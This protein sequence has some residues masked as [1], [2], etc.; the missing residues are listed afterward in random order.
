MGH[1]RILQVF[2]LTWLHLLDKTCFERSSS[3]FKA[4]F[5]PWISPEQ[6]KYPYSTVFCAVAGWFL[7]LNFDIFPWQELRWFQPLDVEK[8]LLCTGF[9]HTFCDKLSGFCQHIEYL[10]MDLGVS[11]LQCSWGLGIEPDILL[12][13]LPCG[14]FTFNTVGMLSSNCLLIEHKNTQKRRWDL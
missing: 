4:N 10:F 6:L 13:Q 8:V 3:S 5:L 14:C 12:R 1:F 9:V 7:S 2:A 11:E